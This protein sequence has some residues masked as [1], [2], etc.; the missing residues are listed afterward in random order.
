MKRTKIVATVADHRS[1]P[2]CIAKLIDAGVNVFRLNSAHS[3][4]ESS[5]K[6]VETIRSVSDKVAVLIDTKGPEIRTCGIDEAIQVKAGDRLRVSHGPVA[7][8]G[9]QVS[10]TRIAE[11]VPLQS[12]MLIDD[13][14]V[15]LRVVAKEPGA[16]ICEVTN[17]GEIAN[18]KSINVPG[19]QLDLPSL[20]E[21]DKEFIDMAIDCDLDFIAHS[22]VRNK[23]DVQCIQEIL[24]ARNSEIKIIAKI[25]NREGIDNLEEILDLAFGVMVARGDLGIEVPME[26]LPA[27]QKRMI[28]TCVRRGKPVITATQMLHTM[29]ENPRP[30][31]AEVSDIA[32]A[33]L[34]GTD[35]LM[36]SGETAYGQY[37]LE[38][39]QTMARIAREAERTK[40]RVDHGGYGGS[41]QD[42][43]DSSVHSFFASAAIEA[44]SRLPL[45]A[46]VI[47]TLTGF[48][49][50]LCAAYRDSCPLYAVSERQRTVRELALTYGVRAI[51]I[52]R[53]SSAENA[54]CAGISGALDAE[55]IEEEDL[56][57]FICGTHKET[58]LNNFL[59]IGTPQ[60]LVCPI[61][62]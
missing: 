29:I 16:L 1:T 17:S 31:R 54:V 37:A 5:R 6:V 21:R 57:A 14:A 50:R 3:S 28:D 11:E 53:P 39:V 45:K 62:K 10:Y 24:D 35:A 48:T 59:H 25:E 33:V 47:S 4:P 2:E 51:R 23:A 30:T 13:G 44:A 26:Q 49:A 38:S 8:A 34:D 22:F 43:L 41:V 20:T 18:R 52:D 32:N 7:T 46:I 56:I 55:L 58:G 40:S 42:T 19:T 9:F 27:M 60:M 61:E 36:L 15:E 12:L